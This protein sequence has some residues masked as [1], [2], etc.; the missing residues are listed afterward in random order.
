MYIVIII[1]WSVSVIVNNNKFVKVSFSVKYWINYI[2]YRG[3]VFCL[4]L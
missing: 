3:G 1:Y 2:L 4:L